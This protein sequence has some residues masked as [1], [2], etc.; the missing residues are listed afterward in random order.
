MKLRG[1]TDMIAVI[2]VVMAAAADRAAALSTAFT[3][4]GQ[5][6]QS[7]SPVNDNC[8]FQFSLWNAPTSGSQ[9]DST[10][11]ASGVP[12]ADGLFTALLDFGPGAFTGDNRWL[13]IAVSCPYGTG[14]YTTLNPRQFLSAAPYALYASSAGSASDL[15]CSGCVGSSDLASGAVT[16]SKIASGTI[17]TNN[18]AFTPGTVT[19]VSAGVGL[20]G[21]PITTS[22]IIS[23]AF[24]TTA[25]T[26]AEG[27]HQHDTRYWSVTGN[28]GMTQGANFLGTTDFMPLDFRVN[29]ARAL[30]LQPT[31]DSPNLIG[32]Y[33]GNSV[34]PG[35]VGGTIAGGGTGANTNL[36]TD[37]YGTIGGGSGNQAG[38]D[39]GTTSDRNY[40]TVSGGGFNVASGWGS[41]VGG[42]LQNIASDS[43]GTV[44]G[45]ADN[46][47]GSG[48]FATVGGGE[49]NRAFAHFA[50]IA[51]G[52][53]SDRNDPATANRVTDDYG[54][55]SG[56]GNNQA[57]NNSGPST[58]ATYATVGGGAGNTASGYGAT[59]GG[60]GANTASSDGTTI[61]GGGF[62]LAT[63]DFATVPGGTLNFA[64]AVGSFA[65]G[66][67]S[68]AAHDGSFVWGDGTAAAVSQG[69][70]TFNVLATGGVHF[71]FDAAGSHC[72]LNPASSTWQCTK[73]LASDRNIKTNV[74]AVEGR[75]VLGRLVAVPIQTWSYVNETPPVRHVGPMAQDFHAAFQ[76]GE[77]D[78]HINLVDASGVALAAIQGLYQIMQEKDADLV[79]LRQQNAALEARVAALEQASLKGGANPPQVT[80]AV[81][82]RPQP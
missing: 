40:A 15:S 52:G 53:R 12:V 10:E 49:S 13:Q 57:G 55:V 24:G 32:G 48:D 34:S 61:G 82:G 54:T 39:G 45:G 28:A 11:T 18:L 41:V 69:P 76:V 6:Q 31:G 67:T 42:G 43:H 33:P 36:V 65:A 17:D 26:V 47:A 16:S 77:D 80:A 4:Q 25:G 23:A 9:I 38:N 35:V 2:F 75:D 74:A 5:L 72:D 46:R 37:D 3:Y 58:D 70:N 59:I 79:A 51:G 68:W 30:R 21:G 44:G 50:T 22:G 19:S 73:I 8:D 63:A 56:G 78:K 27:D 71:Y 64:T 7:A 62:N 20:T 29:N 14:I 66:R 60:G 81:S 1:A